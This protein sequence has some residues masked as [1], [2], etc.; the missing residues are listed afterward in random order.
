M[1]WY[2]QIPDIRPRLDDKIQFP[3]IDDAELKEIARKH[4][5]WAYITCVTDHEMSQARGGLG[6]RT[7]VNMAA[8][9]FFLESRLIVIFLCFFN[10]FA[11]KENVGEANR[12]CVSGSQVVHVNFGEGGISQCG[13]ANY[14]PDGHGAREERDEKLKEHAKKSQVPTPY[15][16]LYAS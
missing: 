13:L 1:L 11:I 7:N 15:Q 5:D 12:V 10:T 14:T 9:R 2:N 16:G 4:W 6:L 8:W 3:I